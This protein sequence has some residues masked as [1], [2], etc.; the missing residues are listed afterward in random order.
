MSEPFPIWCTKWALSSGI[1]EASAWEF[2]GNP[3]WCVCASGRLK[4]AILQSGQWHRTKS[5]AVKEANKVLASAI[6][7]Q[8]AR[9]EE[10]EGVVFSEKENEPQF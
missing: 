5:A 9:L 6:R 7:S 8:R 2:P 1:E 4:G 3:E 10:L